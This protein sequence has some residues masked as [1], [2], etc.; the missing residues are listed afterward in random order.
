MRK[1]HAVLWLLASLSVI[2]YLDRICISLAGPRLP[3][4]LGLAPDQWS[5]VL[6]AFIVSYGLFEIPT[7]AMGDRLGHRRVLTRIVVWWSIFTSLTGAAW[8]YGVLVL[9]RFFFGA[10]EAGAY[11][12]ISGVI[13]RWF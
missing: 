6:N 1:S 12:N 4:E 8:S 2:T 3:A 5:W 10:G 13:S 9:T 7:G 11:P